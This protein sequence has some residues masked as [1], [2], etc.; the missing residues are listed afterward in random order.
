MNPGPGNHDPAPSVPADGSVRTGLRLVLGIV[1]AA[2]GVA[3][4]VSPGGFLKI[5]PTWV[6]YPDAVVFL[7]GVAEIAGG[8]CLAFVPRLRWA[9]AIGLALYAVCVFPANINHALNNI[10]IGGEALTWRYHGPRLAF[11]PVIVWLALWTGGVTNWPFST[12][13]GWRDRESRSQ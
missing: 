12:R 2:A 8:L 1:Y 5:T 7:T 6:P 10:A 11:Q 3:H 13:A 4:L 9:A